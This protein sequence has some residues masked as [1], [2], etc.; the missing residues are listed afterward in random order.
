MSNDSFIATIRLLV[1]QQQTAEIRFLIVDDHPQ[2]HVLYRSII[3]RT[4][5]NATFT[6]CYD[7]IQARE[8]LHHSPT[9]NAIILDLVMPEGDGFELLAWIRS[10]ERLHAVPVII[11]S[12]K[13]LT[14]SEIQRLNYPNTVM[15]PKLGGTIDNIDQLLHG[16]TRGDALNPPHL[17]SVARIAMAYIQQHYTQRVSREQIASMAG[18]S[19]SYLT[20][21]FQH[22]LGVTPWVYLTR[23]RIASACQLLRERSDA[24]T[25]IAIAV[26]FDDPGYFS[27]VFRHEIGLSPREYRNSKNQQ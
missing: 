11:I 18:V 10:N 15:R 2:M 4:F 27:K 26:G 23:Y 17:S 12:G 14:R 3:E 9:P 16:I 24:I 8:L 5:P 19:E 22:E 21:V 1:S 13:V 6:S 20:Q 7:G 25:D